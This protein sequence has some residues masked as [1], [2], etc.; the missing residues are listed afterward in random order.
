MIHDPAV[1]SLSADLDATFRRMAAIEGRHLHTIR[2][3]KEADHEHQLSE[4]P[5][6]ICSGTGAPQ[7][8]V[9][10]TPPFNSIV[11]N[12]IE[13]LRKPKTWL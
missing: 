4:E 8:G 11:A 2:T 6:S 10:P 13:T 9:S 7:P 3:L 1:R 5:L 12:A